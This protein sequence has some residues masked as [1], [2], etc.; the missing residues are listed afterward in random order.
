MSRRNKFYLRYD[1]DFRAYLALCELQNIHVMFPKVHKDTCKCTLD[2]VHI[3]TNA[4]SIMLFLF[5]V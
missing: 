2:I 5:V 3:F 4:Y 1:P